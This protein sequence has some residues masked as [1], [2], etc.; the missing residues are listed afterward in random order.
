M[1]PTWAGSGFVVD[2]KWY[3]LSHAAACDRSFYQ[4]PADGNK[5][6]PIQKPLF[7]SNIKIP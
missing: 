4:I 6:N 2:K 3:E 1:A 5:T 7:L